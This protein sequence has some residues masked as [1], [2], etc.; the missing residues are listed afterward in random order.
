MQEEFHPE[1]AAEMEIFNRLVHAGWNLQRIRE[2]ESAMMRDG[3]LDPLLDESETKLLDRIYRYCPMF[4][5][6]CA[7]ALAELRTLQ[8]NRTLRATVP[9]EIVEHIPALVSV[10]DLTKRTQTARRAMAQEIEDDL[11]AP[12]P[13]QAAEQNE[14]TA[15]PAA[16]EEVA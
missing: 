2:L 9:P 12:A 10:N 13:A 11:T 7:R 15:S 16:V 3:I 8:T 4:E 6:L 5:R 14:P 1:A